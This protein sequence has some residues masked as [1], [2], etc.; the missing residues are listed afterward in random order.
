MM[1]MNEGLGKIEKVRYDIKNIIDRHK[2]G[3]NIDEIA[4][5][6]LT[7][8]SRD[9]IGRA[10]RYLYNTKQI[11][12]LDRRGCIQTY[13][14]VIDKEHTSLAELYDKYKR[15]VV[16]LQNGYIPKSDRKELE[17]LLSN[18]MKIKDDTLKVIDI[19]VRMYDED[20]RV[21][22]LMYSPTGNIGVMYEIGNIIP[23]SENELLGF[24]RRGEVI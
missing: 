11:D 3:V 9:Q 15:G 7:E 20:D 8:Y 4:S 5:S 23:K 17:R 19:K 24:I 13:M 12:R 18:A 1:S 2:E 22:T 14:P 21:C 6:K 16:H 10:V